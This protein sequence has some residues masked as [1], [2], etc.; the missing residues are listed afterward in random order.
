MDKE[1]KTAVKNNL[2]RVGT[3]A[4]VGLLTMFFSSLFAPVRELAAVPGE[5]RELQT[6]VGQLKSSVAE[7]PL[8]ELQVTV[9]KFQA[10]VNTLQLKDSMIFQELKRVD[11]N[12]ADNTQNI[13][14]MRAKFDILQDELP[15]AGKRMHD[16][17]AF[18]KNYN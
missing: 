17:E 1:I 13:H 15:R 18:L 9:A 6:T 7:F 10:T 5:I 8:Q 11:I 3:T 4:L 16:V 2:V 14:V 12:T